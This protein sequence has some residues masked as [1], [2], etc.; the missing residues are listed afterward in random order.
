MSHDNRYFQ[1]HG[2]TD[3][4]DRKMKEITKL[5]NQIR[6]I[7]SEYMR[8][9]SEDKFRSFLCRIFKKRY[10]ASKEEDGKDISKGL[11]DWDLNSRLKLI[12]CD[13]AVT[14]F[15]ST[16]LQLSVCV[17]AYSRETYIAI[18]YRC[19]RNHYDNDFG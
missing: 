9:V 17:F 11:L 2:A 16:T 18:A 4:A 3:K 19:F 1:V 14:K 5:R 10:K 15:L 7:S 12:A 6:D 8:S 13:R